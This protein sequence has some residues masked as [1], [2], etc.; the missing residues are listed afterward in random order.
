MELALFRKITRLE[1]KDVGSAT[2]VAASWGGKVTVNAAV[3]D[4]GR[5][6]V[7]YVLCH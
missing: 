4:M 1:V 3:S 7:R 6:L 2:E 5:S